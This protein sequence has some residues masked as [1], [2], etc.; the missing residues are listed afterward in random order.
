MEPA[1]SRLLQ[2]QI[3][4]HVSPELVPELTSFLQ[5]VNGS[6]EHYERDRLLLS[7]AM[8]LSADELKAANRELLKSNEALESFNYAA[9]HDLKNHALN[10]QGMVVVMRKY[11]VSDPEKL[12]RAM[13]YLELSL[14]QF[15]KTIH[16]FLY[17]SK[18]QAERN[19]I[20][21]DRQQLREQ[22]E[23]ECRHLIERKR[24]RIAWVY[25]G[26]E[27]TWPEHLLRTLL[28]NLITNGIKYS[29]PN[30]LPEVQVL[31]KSNAHTDVVRVRDNGC[32][33]DLQK[34]AKNLFALFSRLNNTQGEEGTG[35]GLYL[36]KKLVERENGTLQVES[37]PGRGTTMT[38]TF[39]HLSHGTR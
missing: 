24:A 29:Q 33:M 38:M 31:M 19:D 34:N 37:Q 25:E 36:V 16:G 9:A 35:V 32:G 23:L 6:Y 5:Q 13:A 15:M 26:E 8:E 17:V 39:T 11:Q 28:V 7:R 22:V 12:E 20:Q 21:V 3:R 1:Y 10:I 2:R 4:K 30:V 14:Q 18:A 27:H